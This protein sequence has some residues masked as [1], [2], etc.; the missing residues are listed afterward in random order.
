M[1]AGHNKPNQAIE[2]CRIVISEKG[3]GYGKAALRLIQKLVFKDWQAHRLWLD[4]KDFNTHALQVYQSVGFVREGVLR[5][6][7][8]T[9]LGFE[10]LIVLSILRQEY[11]ERA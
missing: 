7:L 2:L 11:E 6:C 5:E 10:S 3:K 8:K 1:L 4:V 9:D